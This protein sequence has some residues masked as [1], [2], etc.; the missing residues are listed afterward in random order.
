MREQEFTAFYHDHARPLWL[1]LFKLSGQEALADDIL[2]ESFLRFLKSAPKEMDV[3]HM[4][5]YV[6]R[7][8]YHLFI[9]HQRRKKRYHALLRDQGDPEAFFHAEGRDLE[10]EQ[11]F[12][13]L[14]NRE[15]S[16]L[17]L[18]YVDGYSH[19]EISGIMGLKTGSIRVIINRIK[20]KLK[21]QNEMRN[22]GVRCQYE[23]NL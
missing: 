11:L 10:V 8:A 16:V 15:R 18:A 5:A 2:Q 13:S 9:D 1:Y 19:R 3:H 20:K 23:K 21:A 22:E 6:Y 7:T 4:K 17:W 14:K 12:R